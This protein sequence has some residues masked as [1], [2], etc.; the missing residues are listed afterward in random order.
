MERS[1]EERRG[2]ETD[3]VDKKKSSNRPLASRATPQHFQR[4]LCTKCSL[5]PRASSSRPIFFTSPETTAFSAQN[6]TG[7]FFKLP[8]PRRGLFGSRAL[9]LTPQRAE[10]CLLKYSSKL[11]SLYFAMARQCNRIGRIAENM[12]KHTRSSAVCYAFSIS[13]GDPHSTV[14]CEG[15]ESQQLFYFVIIKL[16]RRCY[17]AI[18]RQF[19]KAPAVASSN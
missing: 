1:R 6:G 19:H 17:H 10:T 18:S 11:S 2:Q 14:T 5:A 7:E 15:H 13:Q 12:L 16:R 3:K 9:S 4:T 8:L